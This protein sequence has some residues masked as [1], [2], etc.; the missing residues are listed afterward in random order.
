MKTL[1]QLAK[2]VRALTDEI[3][4][5]DILIATTQ[6]FQYQKFWLRSQLIKEAFANIR[7]TI[8]GKQ[9]DTAKRHKER[10]LWCK[11]AGLAYTTAAKYRC[12]V[13]AHDPRVWYEN[14]RKQGNKDTS[15]SYRSIR[16]QNIELNTLPGA[17]A[18]MVQSLDQQT[19]TEFMAFP[20]VHEADVVMLIEFLKEAIE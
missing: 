8:G 12:Q 6:D 10:K 5:A 9:C 18:I 11:S 3:D 14:H 16:K 19:P 1:D 4:K 15:K 2:E 7:T 20:S 13:A 17:F